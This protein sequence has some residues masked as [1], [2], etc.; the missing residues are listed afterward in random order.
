MTITLTDWQ[1]TEYTTGS[2]IVYVRGDSRGNTWETGVVVDIILN[3]K[4]NPAGG[5]QWEP[6]YFVMW[7]PDKPRRYSKSTKPGKLSN[8]TKIMAI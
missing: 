6:Q 1:G 4:W 3:P 7:Q 2:R 8:L 5:Y